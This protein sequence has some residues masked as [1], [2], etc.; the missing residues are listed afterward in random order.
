MTDS[1][2]RAMSMGLRQMQLKARCERTRA[3]LVAGE[4]RER[5]RRRRAAVLRIELLAAAG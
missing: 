4:R 2:S 5:D 3:V 1:A